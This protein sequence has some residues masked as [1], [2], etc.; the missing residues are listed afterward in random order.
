MSWRTT[1]Q[2]IWGWKVDQCPFCVACCTNEKSTNPHW[3]HFITKTLSV[4]KIRGKKKALNVSLHPAVLNK[5][6][7]ETILLQS[8]QT[9]SFGVTSRE[10]ACRLN[11]QGNNNK[12]YTTQDLQKEMKGTAGAEWDPFSTEELNYSVLLIQQLTNPV[13][14]ITMAA[15]QTNAARFRLRT[16]ERGQWGQCRTAHSEVFRW[17]CCVREYKNRQYKKEA[18]WSHWDNIFCTK[19]GQYLHLSD[20]FVNSCAKHCRVIEKD[21]YG[22]C[23]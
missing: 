6:T 4:N 9:L 23:T 1:I 5:S 20:I 18:N 2:L 13:V 3:Q 11:V 7:V 17:A 14:V 12:K 8:W 19:G 22:H 21:H 10:N 15:F 16:R